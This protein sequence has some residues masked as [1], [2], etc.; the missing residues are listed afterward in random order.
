M[1]PFFA[2]VIFF[3][4]FLP[5]F[6]GLPVQAQ[7]SKNKFF[8]PQISVKMSLDGDINEAYQFAGPLGSRLKGAVEKPDSVCENESSFRQVLHAKQKS[9]EIW[10][11][12][13]CTSNG[14][15]FEYQPSRFFVN[16]KAPEKVIVLPVLSEKFRK[17]S[18]SLSDL[19]IKDKYN[20]K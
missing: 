7:N 5:I 11:R 17:I 9:L 4:F 1:S 14:Q 6:I 12:L 10:M 19:Q 20:K 13:K 8:V 16:L 3:H 18:V 15:T 2:L